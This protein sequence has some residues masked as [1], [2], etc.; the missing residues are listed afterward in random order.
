MIDIALPG[1]GLRQ[2]TFLQICESSP[3]LASNNIYAVDSSEM[4]TLCSAGFGHAEAPERC[5][6]AP[7]LWGAVR[8]QFPPKMDV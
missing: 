8:T 2:G 1:L 4:S 3:D 6:F 5:S 7:L